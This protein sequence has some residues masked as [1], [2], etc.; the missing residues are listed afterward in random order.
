MPQHDILLAIDERFG[1]QTS[2]DWLTGIARIALES[3]NVGDCQ[4][5]VVITGDDEVRTLNRD[6]AGDDYETDVLA[7][8][9]TEGE[10]FAQP[11]DTR[12]LGEVVISM[13][14]AVKQ[15]YDAGIELDSEVAHLLVHGILHL[16]GYDHL[17][18]DDEATM[19]GHER[20]IL[21]SAGLSAH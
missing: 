5:G 18:S 6:Y 12:R 3:E 15:A 11:D 19:R 21:E 1:K 14:T 17:Q 10:E 8:S 16:L 7:F 9:L 2:A 4:L 13:E 20:A